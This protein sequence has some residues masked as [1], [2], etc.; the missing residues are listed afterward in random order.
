[1]CL[2]EPD[3]LAASF[4]NGKGK[5]W[6]QPTKK[7]QEQSAYRRIAKRNCALL[8]SWFNLHEIVPDYA[9]AVQCA[10]KRFLF[11]AERRSVFDCLH[12]TAIL[13]VFSNKIFY[14]KLTF[15]C[16]MFFYTFDCDRNG[17][18]RKMGNPTAKKEIVEKSFNSKIHQIL[19]R[20]AWFPMKLP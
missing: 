3:A 2:E 7:K 11:F 12:T 1:M 4:V 9:L 5:C 8:L 17:L 15:I 18:H 20:L 14:G 6:R 10:G 13:C 16:K 19:R